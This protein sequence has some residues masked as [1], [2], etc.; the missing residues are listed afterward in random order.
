VVYDPFGGLM[1]V[2]YRAILKG[3]RGQASELS[4]TYFRDGLRHV[5]A[6]EAKVRVPDMF[7]MLGLEAEDAA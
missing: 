6:A 1:T 3:R 7:S 2:P 4:D 5:K